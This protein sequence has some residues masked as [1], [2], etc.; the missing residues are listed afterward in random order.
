[1]DAMQRS[2]SNKWLEAMKSEMKP[3][4]INDVWTLVDLPKGIKFIGCK[5]I[6][7]RKRGADGNVETCKARPVAKRY[8]QCY[9]I[10]YDETFSPMVILKSI[11]IMLA[12]A[13]HLDYEI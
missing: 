9:D 8:R 3:M 11:R 6:F 12:I 1:M 5:W 13:A 7:K 10:D 2:D 4:K